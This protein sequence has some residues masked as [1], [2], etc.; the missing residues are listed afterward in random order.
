MTG[1]ELFELL[2]DLDE[3][4]VDAAEEPPKK[5]RASYLPAVLVSFAAC[6]AV[7]GILFIGPRAGK[8]EDA[9]MNG[10]ASSDMNQNMDGGDGGWMTGDT[11]ESDP[12][13]ESDGNATAGD[14]TPPSDDGGDMT[15]SSG[16]DNGD[17]EADTGSAGAD[18]GAG[19]GNGVTAP[20][21]VDSGGEAVE[22][23]IEAVVVETGDQLVLAPAEG[24]DWYGVAERFV[25]TLTDGVPA[26]MPGDLA[27]G[28]R[29]I[30]ECD[31]E[32]IVS[33]GDG[34]YEIARAQ[35][36]TRVKAS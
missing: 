11:S 30:V 10:A 21:G 14:R 7:L 33:L 13:P 28:E 8:L 25:L 18:D 15:G 20:G 5:R 3:R 34:L 2:G 36:V 23:R 26:D 35:S 32:D 22:C 9:A 6:A 4:L 16:A 27:P 31:R 17:A 19:K 24:N 29:V 12:G 1:V